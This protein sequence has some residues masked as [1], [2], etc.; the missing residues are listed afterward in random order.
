MTADITE[1]VVYRTYGIGR[2]LPV[3]TPV[4]F[5]CSELRQEFLH[6]FW[7]P[8]N[9]SKNNTSY[10]FQQNHDICFTKTTVFLESNVDFFLLQTSLWPKTEFPHV[11][12]N[13]NSTGPEWKGLRRS[14]TSSRSASKKVQHYSMSTFYIWPSKKKKK[15][16]HVGDRDKNRVLRKIVGT[17]RRR[18]WISE[19][20]GGRRKE[21]MWIWHV[22]SWAGWANMCT[23]TWP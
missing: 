1:Q 20:E 11:N 2:V 7:T 23:H 12:N 8:L 16:M 6:L 21:G 13:F 10:I 22:H 3:H 5:C 9:F 17:P 15:V 14:A 18:R 4:F 19:E